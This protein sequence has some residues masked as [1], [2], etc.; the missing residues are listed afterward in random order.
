MHL[1]HI[2]ILLALLPAIILAEETGKSGE[3]PAFIP[4]SAY[5]EQKLSGFTVLIS[6]KLLEHP[7]I[8]KDATALLDEKLAELTKLIPADKIKPVQ[9][10]KFWLEYEQLKKGGACAHHSIDWLKSNGYNPDKVHSIEI[11]NARNFVNWTK[12]NQPMMILH[13]FSHIYHHGVLKENN[14]EIK[15]AYQA[16]LTS[17]KY[18]QVEYSDGGKKRAYGMNNASEYFAELSEAY[19]GRNDFFPFTKDDLKTFDPQ[20]FELMEKS[21]GKR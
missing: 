19:F 17:G 18:D 6:P 13:E 7:E 2:L 4:T 15:A 5:K 21:W 16:A 20:G 12:L 9:E 14:L 11:S 1:K 10:T 3:K 8:C